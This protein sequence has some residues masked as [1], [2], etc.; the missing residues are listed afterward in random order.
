VFPTTPSEACSRRALLFALTGPLA[1]ALLERAGAQEPDA[2]WESLFD[3]VS[4]GS[5]EE[6]PFGGE[7][8]VRVRDG[9]IVL[10]FGE[11]LTGITWRGAHPRLSYELKLEAKRLAGSD[12]FC[13]LTFPVGDDSCSLIL[14]GWGGSVV[15]LSNLDGL[16]ASDNETTT[17]LRFEERR[18]YRVRLRVLPSRITA[19]L[20]DEQ[21]VDVDTTGR[22]IGIRPEVELSR[23]LGIAAYRTRAALRGIAVRPLP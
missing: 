12:F 23:P 7:G 20:D 13:G 8:L 22:R 21:I 14:G 3:G 4:L 17:S 18:W 15:G 11:P 6:T 16:D 2:P 10:E 1:A 5:W 9:Q 19:W